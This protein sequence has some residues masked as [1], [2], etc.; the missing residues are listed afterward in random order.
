MGHFG[1]EEDLIH[2]VISNISDVTALRVPL[3]WIEKTTIL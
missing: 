1:Y 3:Q 2:R